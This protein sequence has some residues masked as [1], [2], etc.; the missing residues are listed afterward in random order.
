MQSVPNAVQSDWE[1]IRELYLKGVPLR[2]IQEQTGVQCTTIASRASRKGWKAIALKAKQVMQSMER[3]IS[4]DSQPSEQGALSKASALVRGKLSDELLRAVDTLTATKPS[5]RVETQ[6]RRAGV[7]QTLSGAAKVIHGW[8]EGSAQPAVRI[9][10]MG[11]AVIAPEPPA[12]AIDVPTVPQ[13]PES[14]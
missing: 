5:K 8:S 10:V 11:N 2:Q 3:P 13:L 9:Q 7:I 14:T 1:V 6:M 4:V 12:P